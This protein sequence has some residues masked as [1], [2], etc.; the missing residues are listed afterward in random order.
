MLRCDFHMH[1]AFSG[2]CATPPGV[3][4]RRCLEVGLNCIAITDHN[5]IMGALEVRKLATSLDN[6]TVIVGEEVKSSQGDIIGL[7][8]E[9]EIPR[10][11]SPLETAHRIKDQGGL[12]V[13]PHPIDFF[14][15]GPL[16]KEALWEIMPYVD[17]I[18]VL[19]ART[20]L[21]GDVQRC[22]RLA[23]DNCITPVAVSDA[24]TPGELGSAYL[25]LEG[26]DGSA[27]SF[28]NAARQGRIVGRRS[29]PF[30]H[31]VTTY[32]KARRAGRRLSEGTF[33]L[34]KGSA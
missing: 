33:R 1:T 22:Y 34:L 8:L 2:D 18:E 5:S 6:L 23:L 10:G 13:V 17:L 32:V 21:P 14:R 29:T 4:V 7:F 28:K 12:V 11:M 3:V 19:N 25:E 15:R 31:L 26:F 9:E 24:H 30:V 20:I 16:S 27:I